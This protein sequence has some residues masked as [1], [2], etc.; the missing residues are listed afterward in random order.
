MR[1]VM[2]Y[3]PPARRKS[4]QGMVAV[5]QCRGNVYYQADWTAATGGRY[6]RPKSYTTTQTENI[7]QLSIACSECTCTVG[8]VIL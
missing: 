2:I 1:Q 4:L 3:S 5:V 7:K 6:D 8:L